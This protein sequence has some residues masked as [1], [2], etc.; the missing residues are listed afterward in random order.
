MEKQQE[1]N[2]QYSLQELLE[3][4]KSAKD[5][6]WVLF[7]LLLEKAEKV[8]AELPAIMCVCAIP[9]RFDQKVL[10][11]LRDRQNEVDR[12][13]ELFSFIST[14][15]Y[16]SMRA[17]G[18]CS[19]QDGIR[20]AVLKDWRSSTEKQ[21]QLTA[22]CNRLSN[23]YIDKYKMV[24]MLEQDLVDVA[25]IMRKVNIVRYWELDSKVSKKLT[26]PLLEAS[27]QRF[28]SSTDEG[29]SFFQDNFLKQ[30]EVGHYLTCEA[31]ISAARDF[32]L[33]LPAEEQDRSQ[34]AWLKYYELRI[35]RRLPPVDY[36][37]L[38]K[39]LSSLSREEGYG[40]KFRMWV[41]AE[42]ATVLEEQQKRPAALQAL[43]EVWVLYENSHEDIWNAP[44]RLLRLG[45]TYWDLGEPDKGIE[46]YRKAIQ[47]ADQEKSVRHDIRVIGR[48]DLS[49]LYC[50]A[51]QWDMA[52]E[53]GLEALLL[54]RTEYSNE[55]SLQNYVAFR[56]MRLLLAFDQQAA[57]SIA[58]EYIALNQG[59]EQM[60]L[61]ALGQRISS[62]QS[63]GR[64][65]LAESELQKLHVKTEQSKDPSLFWPILLFREAYTDDEMGRYEES[66]EKYNELLKLSEAGLV[67][68]W[69]KAA[70]L[71]NRG[72]LRALKG[73][74]DSSEKDLLAALQLWK[75]YGHETMIAFLHVLLADL[76]RRKGMISDAQEEL[77]IAA[78]VFDGSVRIH[79]DD[80]YFIQGEV[81]LARGQWESSRQ[82]FEK[83]YQI[84]SSVKDRKSL[85]DVLHKLCGVTVCQM[86]WDSTVKFTSQLSHIC[87]ELADLNDYRTSD[88][89]LAANDEY[90]KGVL[91][92]CK[93]ENL[94]EACELFRLAQ[95]KVPSNFWYKLNHAFAL[96]KAEF[97]EGAAHVLADA[98]RHAPES[99]HIPRLL[100]YWRELTVKSAENSFQNGNYLKAIT[101]IEDAIESYNKIL[102]IKDKVALQITLA[103]YLWAV[104]RFDEA[105][106]VYISALENADN[107]GLEREQLQLA[108]QQAIIKVMEGQF[109]QAFTELKMR[110]T[111]LKEE[112]IEIFSQGLLEITELIQSSDQFYAI[113][114][115]IRILSKSEEIK[116]RWVI[117]ILNNMLLT[118]TEQYRVLTAYPHG[119]LKLIS[120]YS[121]IPQVTPLIL[122][123][124][125]SLA[126][127]DDTPGIQW[128]IDTGFPNLRDRIL[129]E[130]GVKMPFVSIRTNENINN[131]GYFHRINELWLY[132]HTISKEEKFC[133]EP[134]KCKQIGLSGI[135][136]V[137]YGP[138]GG[139]GLWL[140]ESQ[141]KQAEAEGLILWDVYEYIVYHTESVVRAY[142]AD[143]FGV[144]ELSSTLEQWVA[145]DFPFDDQ[146]KYKEESR[147]N[148][149]NK[150]VCDDNVFLQL[151]SVVRS[152]LREKVPIKHM[153]IILNEFLLAIE[154]SG[155]DIIGLVEQIRMVLRSD[156]PG[157]SGAY[158]QV[159]LPEMLENKLLDGIQF[160]QGKRIYALPPV[161]VQEFLFEIRHIVTENH[162][163]NNTIVVS[164]AILRPLVS[165]IISLEHPTIPVL[166]KQELTATQSQEHA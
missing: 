56:F 19:Y 116:N 60:E 157:A 90:V 58:A 7:T 145:A 68:S 4:L 43:K 13:Q 62:L 134:E 12:N 161:E 144:E 49:G 8:D 84:R 136:A 95:E 31:L 155:N 107:Y 27:Y 44:N 42:L 6:N 25:S 20:E 152:L 164:N 2:K 146:P 108:M 147:R 105:K 130:I 15:S 48:C 109:S 154:K 34:L 11:I 23:Y 53:T 16:V 120:D 114:D 18:D 163:A 165:S 64:H 119:R 9:R 121:L 135:E 101:V 148:T 82:C 39:Q 69:D 106:Q 32:L 52:V 86:D 72:R 113:N 93:G 46:H 17:N 129:K 35:L 77:A 45:K 37:Q 98:L 94:T 26:S 131:D 22:I 117:D 80:F 36:A 151:L 51:G 74:W 112:Q 111:N 142:L 3:R 137:N 75:Q 92:F 73:E 83:A 76:K 41:L 127:T 162:G 50:D 97:W 118:I 125:D 141:F 122:E 55:I 160:E 81:Y 143:F 133:P 29:F 166:S 33:R 5:P 103:R 59:A 88:E 54:A 87:K 100:H 153:G 132:L 159:N 138:A 128:M 79:R 110:L 71:S 140:N 10:G 21:E 47:I 96:D 91:L 30:E 85:V 139:M 99:M 124:S 126:P 89:E 104:G 57:D 149:V 24:Q 70:A 67:S 115:L 65:K 1:K 158:T 156:L 38:E 63:T 61:G 40:A 102:L 28:L 123:V 150:I 78:N 66:I 14:Q